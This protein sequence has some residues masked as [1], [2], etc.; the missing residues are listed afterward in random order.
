MRMGSM[1][2]ATSRKYPPELRERA[3]RMVAECRHEHP[4]EWATNESV[5]GTLGIGTAQSLLS[6]VRRE[7]V[8][9]GR[10][11]G[12]TSDMAA[13]MRKLRAHNNELKRVNEI[14]RSASVFFA[15]LDRR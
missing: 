10:R 3:V 7:E 9:S 15:E 13:E 8:D 2:S 11:G 5:A 1:S 14:L 4:S 6:W 12:V